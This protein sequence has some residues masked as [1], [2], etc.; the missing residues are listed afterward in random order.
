MNRQSEISKAFNND[1]DLILKKSEIIENQSIHYVNNTSKWTGETLSRMV[2]NGSLTRVSIGYYRLGGS[3]KNNNQMD[4]F[5]V[6]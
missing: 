2:K 5:N 1:Y 3:S 6:N 4:M